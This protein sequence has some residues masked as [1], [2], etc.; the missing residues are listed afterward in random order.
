M[1]QTLRMD[2]RGVLDDKTVT[3]KTGGKQRGH[4]LKGIARLVAMHAASVREATT[5]HVWVCEDHM[6]SGAASAVKQGAVVP[7]FVS[8]DQ[9]LLLWGAGV[10]DSED[11]AIVEGYSTTPLASAYMLL[12]RHFARELDATSDTPQTEDGWWRGGAMQKLSNAM[13]KRCDMADRALREQ[14]SSRL[15]CKVPLMYVY[16]FCSCD[17]PFDDLL[18]VRDAGRPPLRKL[19][20]DEFKEVYGVTRRLEFAAR[21]VV[22]E[23]TTDWWS[24]V[25]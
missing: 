10:E 16:D 2:S 15:L 19:A 8:K 14:T 13:A 20:D 18:F 25:Y 21:R 3:L 1:I 12:E 5:P 4:S 17:T 23:T 6:K 7:L 11:E 24:C 22:R 9:Y